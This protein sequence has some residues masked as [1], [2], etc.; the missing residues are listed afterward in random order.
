M[1]LMQVFSIYAPPELGHTADELDTL[2]RTTGEHTRGNRVMTWAGDF[3]ATLQ[4]M[5]ADSWV[6][7]AGGS[8]EAMDEHVLQRRMRR[9][10]R[11]IRAARA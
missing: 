8:A 1:A 3:N 5:Q 2:M 7:K 10:P 6:G 11:S 4:Q 9:S